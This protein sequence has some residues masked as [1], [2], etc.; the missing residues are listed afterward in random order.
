MNHSLSFDRTNTSLLGRWWWTVDRVG[1]FALLALI[2][3]GAVLVTA[4]S[5]PVAARIGLP[6]YYFVTRQ[7]VFLLLSVGVLI[8]TSMLREQEIRRMATIGCLASLALMALLPFFGAETKGAQ[9]WINIAGFSVQ[10]S[11]FLKPCFAVVVAWMFAERRRTVGFPGYRIAIALYALV[12]F[13]LIIQPDIG[14]TMTVSAMFGAQMFLAGLPWLWVVTM[15]LTGI[16]GIFLAYLYLPHVTQRID[17][18]LHPG[19]TDNYQVEKS[20]EAF[21]SGGLFGR[22]PGEG[23]VKWSI[24]DSHTDFIFSVA[25]EEFGAIVCLLIITLYGLIVLRGIWCMRHEENAF[26]LLAAAG[27]LVQFGVQA[28][29]NMGVAVHVLPAKGMTLP[30]LS[31]GGSSLLAM[32]MGMGI[33]LGLTRRRFGVLEKMKPKYQ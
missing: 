17:G 13:L 5:P 3:I 23:A 29:I 9:R 2:A 31:Y 22:G 21:A 4:A 26:V 14:M 16:G 20:L 24:P 1:L 33:W 28:V 6:H 19:L 25:G 12:A 27:I 11:E 10:P 18:F 15:G 8:V 32:A 30:F 7:Q